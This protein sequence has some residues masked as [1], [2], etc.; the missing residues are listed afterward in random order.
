MMG[1]C[2]W[3]LGERSITILRSRNVTVIFAGICTRTHP[4]RPASRWI[5]NRTNS[6]RL[7]PAPSARLVHAVSCRVSTAQRP[8]PTLPC[9]TAVQRASL[10][11][12]PRDFSPPQGRSNGLLATRVPRYVSVCVVPTTHSMTSIRRRGAQPTVDPD[13]ERAKRRHDRSQ[14]RAA[15]RADDLCLRRQLWRRSDGC[16]PALH[17]Q[18]GEAQQLRDRR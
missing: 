1:T 3:V 12:R 18:P 7:T 5:P 9:R 11:D 4:D 10:R 16:E 17:E 13:R 2:G 6:G 8:A 14:H 15:R